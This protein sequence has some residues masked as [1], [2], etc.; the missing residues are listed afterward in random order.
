[1]TGLENLLATSVNDQPVSAR[2]KRAA[3]AGTSLPASKSRRM[4]PPP[5]TPKRCKKHVRLDPKPEKKL[6]FTSSGLTPS[7]RRTTLSSTRVPED[8][9]IPSTTLHN[10]S[11]GGIPISGT[12]QF[13]PLLQMLDG[14][15]IRRLKR[16]GLSEES[17]NIERKTKKEVR[18]LRMEVERL[19][20][21]SEAAEAKI[22]ELEQ[23]ITDLKTMLNQKVF[24]SESIKNADLEMAT[25]G[26]ATPNMDSARVPTNQ[27]LHETQVHNDMTK[28]DTSFPSP[29]PTMPN[30]PCK[31]PPSTNPR[32]TSPTNLD[33]AN[34]LINNQ[35]QSGLNPNE[36][37]LTH[38]TL[39]TSHSSIS[40]PE[41][42][43]GYMETH[44][45]GATE[46][47]QGTRWVSILVPYS[48]ANVVD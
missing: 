14:R 42:E 48:A 41:K 30:T 5:T 2:R 47:R 26:L 6:E 43:K 27:D 10:R 18:V 13:E 40:R 39:K 24:E 11:N 8:H 21:E 25:M 29:P 32:A 20:C 16:R 22:Q 37:K 7:M 36:T 19:K 12:V 15:L 38:D 23:Q 44:G 33:S 1:M 17:N 34:E 35:L 4:S 28:L 31:H 45:V 46:R 3:M 9:Y